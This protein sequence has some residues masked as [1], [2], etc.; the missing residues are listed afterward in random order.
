MF[1]RI[2]FSTEEPIQWKAGTY[3]F[4]LRGWRN[5]EDTNSAPSLTVSF[6]VSLDE[7]TANNLTKET[8]T[9]RYLPITITY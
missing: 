5:E 2:E 4:E 1:R 6:S 9:S 3:E 8:S 7:K